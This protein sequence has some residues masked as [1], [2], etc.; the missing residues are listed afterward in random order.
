MIT[1]AWITSN[2]CN[3]IQGIITLSIR[4]LCLQLWMVPFCGQSPVSIGSPPGEAM[5]PKVVKISQLQR[6]EMLDWA[7]AQC[8]ETAENAHPEASVA[9]LCGLAPPPNHSAGTLG[10]LGT[11][12]RFNIELVSN[13]LCVRCSVPCFILW[14][15]ELGTSLDNLLWLTSMHAMNKGICLVP[16][17]E[18]IFSAFE[19]LLF[20][21]FGID[22]WCKV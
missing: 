6:A 4:Y 8:Y 2:H 16:G 21:W 22:D 13:S 1:N 19:N 10:T 18:F 15:L 12:C 14:D 17:G 9:G 7:W 11:L 3:I 5:P 20:S